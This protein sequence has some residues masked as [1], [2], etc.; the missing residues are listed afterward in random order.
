MSGRLRTCLH[1]IRMTLHPGIA[2]QEGLPRRIQQPLCKLLQ[3]STFLT[4]HTPPPKPGKARHH[5]PVPDDIDILKA[6]AAHAGIDEKKAFVP[7]SPSHHHQQQ[8]GQQQQ[9]PQNPP[10]PP[11]TRAY[12]PLAAFSRQHAPIEANI[13]AYMHLPQARYEEAKKKVS[14]L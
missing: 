6:A 1:L 7:T 3:L 4:Q 9:Q 13:L 2:D 5:A 14:N 11:K 12:A 10:T 8:Q